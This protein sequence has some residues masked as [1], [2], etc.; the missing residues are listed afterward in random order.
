MTQSSTMHSPLGPQTD[1]ERRCFDRGME[2]WRASLKRPDMTEEDRVKGALEAYCR[3]A[4]ALALSAPIKAGEAVPV[5]W[6]WRYP[7]SMTDDQSWRFMELEPNWVRQRGY[8]VEPLYASPQA[9]GVRVTDEMVKS[10]TAAFMTAPG[11]GNAHL[12]RRPLEVQ[13]RAA[14]EAALSHTEQGAAHDPIQYR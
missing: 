7:A 8:P 13:M 6:R 4:S 5:A 9:Y 1:D 11:V 10:A 14:L 12:V 2:Q 3:Q